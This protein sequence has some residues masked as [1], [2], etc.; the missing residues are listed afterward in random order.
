MV[1]RAKDMQIPCYEINSGHFPMLTSSE[2]L[3][4]LILVQR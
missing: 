1:I 3:V 2:A 4:D